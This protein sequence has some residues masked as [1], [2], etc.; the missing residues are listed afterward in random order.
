MAIELP[1]DDLRELAV[2]LDSGE[3]QVL[4][5]R[6]DHPREVRQ[7]LTNFTPLVWLFPFGIAPNPQH[8]I[9]VFLNGLTLWAD[10]EYMLTPVKSREAL[11]VVVLSRPTTPADRMQ[12]TYTTAVLNPPTK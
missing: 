6:F 7:P 9:Q 8:T 5:E 2:I 10:N 3:F 11:T 1:H 4:R 12:A